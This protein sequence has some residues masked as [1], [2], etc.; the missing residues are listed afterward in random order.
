MQTNLNIRYNEF[1]KNLSIPAFNAMQEAVI[2]LAESA[3]NMMLLAPTGTGKTLGFLTAVFNNLNPDEKGVQALVVAP[4]RELALQIEQVFKNM[5]TSYKVSCCYGGHSVRIEQNSLSEAPAL[6]IG[7]PGRLAD[8]IGRRSFDASTVKF[9][10]L[11]EFDKS[12]QMGFRPQLEIL[13]REMNGK[14]KHMLT[15]ATTLDDLPDFLPFTNASVLDY[16]QNETL[17]KLELKLV[18]TESAEKV[19]TLMRLVAGF[20]QEITLVFCNHKD[21]VERISSLLRSHKFAHGTFHGDLEQIEREKS[22]IKFRGGAHNV[23][24]ATDLAARG[25]DIPEIKHVVHYQLP[26]HHESFLHRNGRTAR[27]HADGK[28]YL[29]LAS[30]EILPDYI[31]EPTE[32]LKP[33][34]KLVLPPPPEFVCVY[35]SAGKK[36][37]ISKGDIAGLLM[38]KGE[39][40]HDEIGLISLLDHAT[41]VSVKRH[42][43][44]KVLEKIKNERLK[45]MKVKIEIAY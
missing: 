10:V 4:S 18:R 29:I 17:S 38:K 40:Q 13:F 19:E 34:V 12:L 23:L 27:M 42:A 45:K 1:L 44:K 2:T 9:V 25:L 7:T 43:V 5:K 3:D 37:K 11:D 21:A 31:T 20:N 8:H 28:A 33:D 16:R 22:L 14:Q 41:Y 32:E 30:D 26:I 6:I 15:S 39:L 36:E 24:I 35:F